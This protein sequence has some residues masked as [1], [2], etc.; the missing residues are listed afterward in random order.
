MRA[1]EWENSLR[2]LNEWA[3]G[4]EDPKSKGECYLMSDMGCSLAK[5]F[6]PSNFGEDP[7]AVEGLAEFGIGGEKRGGGGYVALA[8]GGGIGRGGVD[9]EVGGDVEGWIG[10]GSRRRR[11]R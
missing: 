9:V 2:D 4:S 7:D 8:C 5:G 3:M 6:W 10:R 1:A 11:E